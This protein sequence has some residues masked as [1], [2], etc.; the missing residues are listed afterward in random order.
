MAAQ[1]YFWITLIL[2]IVIVVV[3]DLKYGLLRDCSTAEMRSFSFARVQL[4]WWTVIILASMISTILYTGLIPTFD[5]STLILLGISS[6]TLAT[7]AAIDVSDQT[8]AETANTTKELSRNQQSSGFL[9]DIL[10]DNSGISI[11]RFQTV[12]FN[13][14]FG[15]WMIAR[16]VGSL[17]HVNAGNLNG[18]IPIVEP[19]NLILIGL[20]SATYAAMKTTENKQSSKPPS[21]TISLENTEEQPVG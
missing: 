8:R 2:L 11:H 10:S 6:T 20:S 5:S 3:T 9:P 21:E 13:F 16:I 19:N 14:V 7:A 12:A 4:T 15:C 17:A 18:V 1:T